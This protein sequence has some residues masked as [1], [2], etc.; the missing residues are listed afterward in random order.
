MG[1]KSGI[2]WTDDTDNIIVVKGGGW[3]CKKI[4]PECVNCYAEEVNDNEYFR[5]NHRPYKGKPPELVLRREMIEGWA[6]Q[7][8]P[9]KHFV[10]SMTDVFGEWLARAWHFEFLDGM[11]AA[12][13][14]TFQILT[15][16]AGVM[17]KSV[18]LWMAARGITRPP[19]NIW[20]G[21]SAGTQKRFDEL[22]PAMRDLAQMGWTIFVSCEPLLEP[23]ILPDDFLALGRR[24]QVI[25]GGESGK[26]ARPMHPDWVRMLRFQCRTWG[27][28]FFFKQWG[29]LIDV[30]TAI[31]EHGFNPYGPHK[32]YRY[33][34]GHSL[35]FVP[36]DKKK[37]GRLLD[38]EVWSEF[39][40][41]AT[42]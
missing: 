28:A 14:Q 38:G 31:K 32:P 34:D 23:V 19:Q 4:S 16:R 25:V 27:V 9:R 30:D 5:G 24:A 17:L 1:N 6:R 10:A 42:A 33:I 15:K 40:E 29:S 13:L 35:P 2:E 37:A 11:L 18:R 3:W 41:P 12:P 22:W 21:F 39:P 8:R 7:R 20:L 26:K 36:F